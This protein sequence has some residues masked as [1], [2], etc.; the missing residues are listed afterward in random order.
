MSFYFII[1][2]VRFSQVE[3]VICQDVWVVIYTG[4]DIYH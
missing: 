4:K 1:F 2:H 3:L